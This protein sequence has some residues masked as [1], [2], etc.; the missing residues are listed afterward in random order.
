M[1]K[2]EY[3]RRPSGMLK[4]VVM[5]RGFGVAG[6]KVDA[7]RTRFMAGMGRHEIAR[8]LSL[9]YSAV[10]N[11]ITDEARKWREEERLARLVEDERRIIVTRTVVCGS[12]L[13]R[14]RQSLP[15]VSMH[16]AAL[17]GRP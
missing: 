11:T 16:V 7:V 12:E 6:D 13:R 8:E 5:L 10:C 14:V 2:S 15:R 1:S 3:M 9:S 4:H 17:E